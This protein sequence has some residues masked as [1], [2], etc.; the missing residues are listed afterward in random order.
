MHASDTGSG[1]AEFCEQGDV[2]DGD[3]RGV[4]AVAAGGRS[5]HGY[6]APEQAWVAT[7][8]KDASPLARFD[9][10]RENRGAQLPPYSLAGLAFAGANLPAD[11]LGRREGILTAQEVVHLDLEACE[12]ATLSA[13]KTSLGVRRAGTGLASLREAFH[14]AGARFV[15]ATLWEVSDVEAQKL[16]AGFYG[17]LWK[18]G[19]GPREALRGAKA[20]ARTR[21]VPFRDWAGFVIS[22]R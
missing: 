4:A 13:C 9:T 14:A 18:D 19:Q 11:A 1:R 16:M 20:V 12:L 10:G 8:P 15:L 6:F 17:C 3:D 5:T 2:T 22:G 21:G 7:D